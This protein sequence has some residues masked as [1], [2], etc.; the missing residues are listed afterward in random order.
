MSIGKVGS[1]PQAIS[2]G[3]DSINSGISKTNES[4]GPEALKAAL[5]LFGPSQSSSLSNIAAQGFKGP[6]L[7]PQAHVPPPQQFFNQLPAVQFGTISSQDLKIKIQDPR[8]DLQKGLDGLT[9][10]F[11]EVKDQLKEQL[12]SLGD[13]SQNLAFDL[14]TAM[15]RIAQ[16]ATL[17]SNI[18]AK[19][20]SAKDAIIGNIRG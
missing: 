17:K 14:Q 13:T 7:V 4:G 3:L 8:L 15:T 6:G 18:S 11:D 12:D 10:S 9:F 16:A 2:S 5:E 1:F 19:D 20:S